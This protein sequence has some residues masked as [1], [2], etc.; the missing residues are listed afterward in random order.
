MATKSRK[1]PVKKRWK[2]CVR[3]VYSHWNQ[4]AT[5]H[6]QRRCRKRRTRC[7][8]SDESPC[9]LCR[10]AEVV[11]VFQAT[12][13]QAWREQSPLFLAHS[14]NPLAGGNSLRHEEMSRCLPS[15]NSS[16]D[17]PRHPFPA[18]ASGS[19]S[20]VPKRQAFGEAE[21]PSSAGER[22]GINGSG[23]TEVVLG[24]VEPVLKGGKRDVSNDGASR[25]VS[26]LPQRQTS[27]G[28]S[29]S[30]KSQGSDWE[31]CLKAC[32]RSITWKLQGDMVKS[33]VC[34]AYFTA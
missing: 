8:S 23:D 24:L 32:S 34:I 7:I 33:K 31:V 13:K 28:T 11:C 4:K 30:A 20:R 26:Y 17:P 18:R 21:A 15:S 25:R 29:S 22:P 3:S 2:A 6:K 12:P 9:Q 27:E 10:K 19:V 1:I 5:D 16:R 14:P